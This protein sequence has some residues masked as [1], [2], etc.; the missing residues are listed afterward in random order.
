MDILYRNKTT[1]SYWIS[2]GILFL[3]AFLFVFLFSFTTSP[4]FE[5]YQ[6]WTGDSG[7]FQ[8]MGICLAQGGTPYL[9]IFDHKGPVLWFIQAF[10]YK[11]SPCWGHMILQTISLFCTLVLWY[12]IVHILTK[13]IISSI[14][15]TLSGLL[16]LM[17]FYERG[18]LCEEWS[19]PFISLPIYLYFRRLELNNH[20][21]P[22]YTRFDSFCLGL[23]VG[24][25]AMIRLNNTAPLIGFT[26][27]HLLLCIKNKEYKRLWTDVMIICSGMMVVF[28]ICSVFYFIK[29]NWN[30]VY[31]MFYGTFIFNTIYIE[32][33][34]PPVK[35]YYNYILPLTF[36][37]IS[38]FYIFHKKIPKGIS[39]ALFISYIITFISI[40]RWGYKHYMIIFIPLF[41][42]S[43]CALFKIVTQW[44]PVI[45][46]FFFIIINSINLGYKSIDLL[47]FRL[48]RKQANTELMDGFH[49]FIN[50]ISPS[51]QKRIYNNGLNYL[52]ASLFAN[53]N[54]YQ[55]NRIIYDSHINL[56]PRIKA[57]IKKHGIKELQPIWVLTQSPRP[58]T[59]DEYMATHYTL[60]DSIPGG[61]FDPIWCWKRNDELY[62]LEPHE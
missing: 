62:S 16:F 55:Y 26:F 21:K 45:F 30:G 27:W 37:I 25:I 11:I 2:Y 47:A 7:I 61:E 58:E 15:I 17:A 44:I 56:S 22:I 34:L 9:D 35:K 6:F 51:E 50:S 19:L 41:L 5:H 38:I 29:A 3:A 8:E 28:T 40:G 12:N 53:E 31:E 46:I 36:I 48:K 49:K 54:I 33:G 57:Y 23:C 39:I 10:G 14:I 1:F 18:N 52:G 20:E 24:I 60:A 59:N 42:V 32:I 43:I 13:K 4:F